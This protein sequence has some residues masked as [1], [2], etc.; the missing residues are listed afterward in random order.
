[1]DT[2]LPDGFPLSQSSSAFGRPLLIDLDDRL[3]ASISERVDTDSTDAMF[4][5]CSANF[6][7]ADGVLV[8]QQG[9]DRIGQYHVPHRFAFHGLGGGNSVHRPLNFIIHRIVSFCFALKGMTVAKRRSRAASQRNHSMR[10][11]WKEDGGWLPD[12]I[13]DDAIAGIAFFAI[14]FGGM[15]VAWGLS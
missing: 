4:C 9:E 11:L 15:F 7:A 6:I 5:D 1:M 12:T 13:V 14:F 10:P 3:V 2:R 8:G